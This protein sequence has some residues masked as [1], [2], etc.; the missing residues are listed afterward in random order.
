MSTE[1]EKAI[2]R[3][4]NAKRQQ[5]L[6][7]DTK[8]DLQLEVRRQEQDVEDAITSELQLSGTLKWS[9]REALAEGQTE[10]RFNEIDQKLEQILGPVKPAE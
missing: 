4:V 9:V 3:W 8:G 6:R 7:E 2:S 10:S 5:V 1:L